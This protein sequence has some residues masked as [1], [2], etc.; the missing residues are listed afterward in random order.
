[1]GMYERTSRAAQADF[2]NEL[3]WYWQLRHRRHL[4]RAQPRRRRS[5]CVP[6]LTCLADH[7][8]CIVS[9]YLTEALPETRSSNQLS[10]SGVTWG[11]ARRGDHA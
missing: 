2:R 7:L 3:A 10:L 4:G 6:L 11:P 8:F 9:P 1:M 5:S